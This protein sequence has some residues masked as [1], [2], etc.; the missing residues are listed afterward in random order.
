MQSIKSRF[1][2]F[3][4]KRRQ[5]AFE[6]QKQREK[7]EA[8]IDKLTDL[9]LNDHVTQDT[10]DRKHSHLQL[11]HHE[12]TTRLNEQ[13][14]NSD[15]LENALYTFIA[16]LNKSL[17]VIKSSKTTEIR[18]LL[19]TLFSNFSLHGQNLCYT[20]VSVASFE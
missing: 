17:L 1:V 7:I 6:L 14:D 11:R 19:K 13:Y 5:H 10:Y 2:A 15:N 18:S 12:I 4:Y 9:L 20:L 8:Q 16:L 3:C